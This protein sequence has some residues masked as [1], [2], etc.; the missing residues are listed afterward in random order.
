MLWWLIKKRY[1]LKPNYAEAYNNLG[2]TLLEQGEPD[3]AIS[4]YKKA[5]SI[6]SNYAEANY[7]MG[8]ALSSITNQKRLLLHIIMLYL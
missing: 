5:I 2:N 1:P 4:S 6:D 8:F 7:N 3:G